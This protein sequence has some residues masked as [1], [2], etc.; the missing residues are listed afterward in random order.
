MQKKVF[1]A[2]FL[3]PLSSTCTSL[4]CV[5][6]YTFTLIICRWYHSSLTGR[7][8]E[9][10]LLSKGQDGSF[11]V[12]ASVHNPGYYILSARVDERVSHIIIR[13]INGVFDVGGG[14]TFGGLT[15]LIEHYKKNPVIERPGSVIHLKHPFHATSFLPANI[16]QR[17]SELQKQNPDVYGKTGFWEEFEVCRV[18]YVYWYY[19]VSRHEADD[20]TCSTARLAKFL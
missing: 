2:Y 3:L 1:T 14:P 15:P 19:I 11:L 16:F 4:I 7:E 20:L 12:R 8:A 6:C 5:F 17:V 13:N 9:T 10:L 18:A